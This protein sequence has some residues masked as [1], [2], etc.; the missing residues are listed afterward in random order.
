MSEDKESFLKALEYEIYEYKKRMG[1]NDLYN[2]QLATREEWFRDFMIFLEYTSP[3]GNLIR[4][5]EDYN[6]DIISQA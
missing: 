3:L 1:T 4:A 2:Q 5:V 6:N